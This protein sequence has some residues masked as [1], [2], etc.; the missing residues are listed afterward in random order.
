MLRKMTICCLISAL[1]ALACGEGSKS[2]CPSGQELHEDHHPNGKKAFRGCADIITRSEEGHWTWWHESGRKAMEGSFVSG[3]EEGTWTW[4]YENGQKAMEGAFVSGLEEGLW[5]WWYQTGQKAMEGSFAKGKEEG[6]WILWHEN[7]QKQQ[8]GAY[9]AGKEEG[10]WRVWYETGQERM[11][12]LF[13]DGKREGTWLFWDENGEEEEVFY[14]NGHIPPTEEELDA[15]LSLC[16]RIFVR[17]ECRYKS[18]RIGDKTFH[19][20]RDCGKACASGEFDPHA[21]QCHDEY[22]C[23]QQSLSRLEACLASEN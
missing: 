14:K 22:F 11:Q 9:K 20:E 15:C 19:Q 6:M 17:E 2:D 4:W 3:L 13:I 16:D 12:G 1:C 5:T 23:D 8:E 10:L 7:G 21:V 18:F